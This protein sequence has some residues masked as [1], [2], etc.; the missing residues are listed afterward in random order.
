MCQRG[1][2]SVSRTGILKAIR[3]GVVAC[4]TIVVLS[5]TPFAPEV[6]QVKSEVLRMCRSARKTKTRVVVYLEQIALWG[7]TVE[8]A[9]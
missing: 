3:A 6:Q 7:S 5:P 1:S 2:L 4:E 8:L 9:D